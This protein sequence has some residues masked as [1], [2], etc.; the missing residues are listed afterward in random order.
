M[1]CSLEK[2]KERCCYQYKKKILVLNLKF[3]DKYL[4]D[5]CVFVGMVGDIADK[6]VDESFVCHS[7]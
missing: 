7:F 5:V 6:K 2:T 1:T 3:F 4:N